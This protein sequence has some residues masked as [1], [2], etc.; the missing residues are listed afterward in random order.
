MSLKIKPIKYCRSCKSKDLQIILSSNKQS[1]SDFLDIKDNRKILKFPLDIVLCKNCCLVQLET[2]TPPQ[3]LYTERYG[4]RSGMNQTMKNEL[5]DVVENV[6]KIISLNE[7][8]LVIDIGCNDGTLLSL[9]KNKRLMHVGFD[10]VPTFKKYFSESMKNAKVSSYKLITDYFHQEAFIR[11]FRDQQ[12]KVITAI[13]M[14]YDLEDPNKFLK[15]INKCLSDAGLFVIQQNYL[16]GMFKQNAFDNIV[17]EHLEYYT[18]GS[19]EYLLKKHNLEVFDVSERDING[20]SFRT[21]IRKEGSKVGGDFI[22]K[23][24]SEMRDNEQKMG[25][26]KE[27]VY[28]LFSKRVDAIRKKIYE[29]IKKE[30]NKGKLIY[31]YGASTRGSTL[32]QA[33]NLDNKLIKAAIERNPEKWG[34]KMA[35]L[36]IPIISEDQA[37]KDHPDYYLVLPWFFKEEF[38]KREKD[39]L[40][41]G[42]KMIFPLPNFEIITSK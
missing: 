21:Y 26:N 11:E 1:L 24:V 12:V 41:S 15:D 25:L 36:G 31:A 32:L 5:A 7:K 23:K 40:S 28:R 6:E 16:V 2:S 34:K 20:G 3:L 30:A 14:F 42:G 39:Y 8:D 4:Y 33:C 17:H 38:I 37:R 9:Y 19:L 10:P 29:F 13:S 18:L 27:R 22:N 35:A